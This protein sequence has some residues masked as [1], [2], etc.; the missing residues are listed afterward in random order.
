[1][2]ENTIILKLVLPLLTKVIYLNV[3]WGKHIPYK[4]EGKELSS[5]LSCSRN[6]LV[7]N[8]LK[9]FEDEGMESSVG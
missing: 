7:E 1:M 9:C 5:P 4:G 3:F 6:I 8:G 2:F